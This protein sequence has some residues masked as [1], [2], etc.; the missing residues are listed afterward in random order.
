MPCHLTFPAKADMMC[1]A[2]LREEW[3]AGIENHSHAHIDCSALEVITA[4]AAQ[5]V[6]SLSKG[7]GAVGGSVKLVE[8][9]PALREDFLLL[10]L[11]DF[12]QESSSHA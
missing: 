3:L 11:T 9:S 2:A 8:V 1:V 7:L 6:V 10:G 12:L 5:L 4:A